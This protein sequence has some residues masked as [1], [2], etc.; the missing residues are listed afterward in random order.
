PKTT[1]AIGV[2]ALLSAVPPLFALGSEFMPPLNEGDILYMPTT[3]PNVSIEEAKRQLVRQDRV[4]ASF[5]EV[6]SVFGKVGRAESPTDPAP[7]SMVETVVQLKPPSEWPM[8]H[9]ERWYSAHAPGFVKPTL[10]LVW[11]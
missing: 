1:L 4:I 3:L 5:P 6:K 11:P 2:F 7:L 8:V 9:E 10:R